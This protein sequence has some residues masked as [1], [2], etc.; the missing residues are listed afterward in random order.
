MG[1]RWIEQTS[2]SAVRW[3]VSRVRSC[4]CNACAR[5]RSV[6]LASR[7]ER[8]LLPGRRKCRRHRK[9]RRGYN[10]LGASRARRGTGMEVA[11][12]EQEERMGR[13]VVLIVYIVMSFRVAR[14]VQ[15]LLLDLLV[16]G[17]VENG[18]YGC[19]T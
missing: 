13:T 6:S 2:S 12:L 18:L 1:R 3:N 7:T 10:R 5:P 15:H 11:E 16:G 14:E 19:S 4:R 8:Q 9:R 17:H